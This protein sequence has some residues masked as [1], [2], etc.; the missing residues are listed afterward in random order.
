MRNS[1]GPPSKRS[2]LQGQQPRDKRLPLQPSKKALCLLQTPSAAVTEHLRDATAGTSAISK[3]CNSS[4]WD[5]SWGS[6]LAFLALARRRTAS[7]LPRR[8][9]GLCTIA[10]SFLQ[11]SSQKHMI[12][13]N[14]CGVDLDMGKIF[15][16][17]PLP[18]LFCCFSCI[19]L[20]PFKDLLGFS[21][22][23]N[24]DFQLQWEQCWMGSSQAPIALS[25]STTGLRNSALGIESNSPIP[26]DGM[27]SG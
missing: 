6:T 22:I 18:M 11:T 16:N 21:H 14:Y 23:L 17:F 24:R 3:I 8:Y 10:A 9:E 20:S 1:D 25:V 12:N 4:W 19:D 27:W 15:L 7:V 2:K 13:Y 5:W 26:F